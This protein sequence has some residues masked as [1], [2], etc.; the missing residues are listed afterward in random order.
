MV[1]DLSPGDVLRFGDDTTLTVLAVEDELVRFGLE[2]LDRCPV[3]DM[4]WEG[5]ASRQGNPG[6]A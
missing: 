3:A 1:F 4:D 5:A 2:S 6:E